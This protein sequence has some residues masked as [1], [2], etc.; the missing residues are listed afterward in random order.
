MTQLLI[1][2]VAARSRKSQARGLNDGSALA[3]ARQ[4]VAVPATEAMLAL[5]ARLTNDIHRLTMSQVCDLSVEIDADRI[6]LRGHC[7]TYYTK[8]VAQQTVIEHLLDG[9]LSNEI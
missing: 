9:V 4:V 6:V 7:E 2:D 5:A 3:A 1:S 8:Q